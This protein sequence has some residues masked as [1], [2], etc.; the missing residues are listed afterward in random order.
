MAG[1][2]TITS[3]LCAPEASVLSGNLQS[4]GTVSPAGWPLVPGSAPAPMLDLQAWDFHLSLYHKLPIIKA[5]NVA[6]VWNIRYKQSTLS[7]SAHGMQSSKQCWITSPANSSVPQLEPTHCI[8]VL[9]ASYAAHRSDLWH[10]KH[11]MARWT[12]RKMPHN[13]EAAPLISQLTSLNA[14]TTEIKPRSASC[15]HK[16][17]LLFSELVY[18]ITEAF[19]LSQLGLVTIKIILI[20]NFSKIND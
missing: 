5:V 12:K 10:V 2:M 16:P 19:N 7:E 13:K 11:C 3:G 15:A 8:H 14:A 9:R 6:P 17:S 1:F 18:P 4:H 20:V